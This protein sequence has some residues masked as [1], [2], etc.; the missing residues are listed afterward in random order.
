MKMYALFSKPCSIHRKILSARIGMETILLDQRQPQ[1]C[2]A[3][4]CIVVKRVNVCQNYLDTSCIF[5][6]LHTRTNRVELKF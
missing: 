6:F 2:S 4:A 5:I 3:Q 1:T